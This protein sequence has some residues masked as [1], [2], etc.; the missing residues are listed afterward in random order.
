MLLIFFI[1]MNI[2][3]LIFLLTGV[4]P[5]VKGPS[6]EQLAMREYINKQVEK[7]HEKTITVSN[8]EEYP[9]NISEIIR[10]SENHP[11]H[12]SYNNFFIEKQREI[13]S[14]ISDF[15]TKKINQNEFTALAVNIVKQFDEPFFGG[16]EDL[17]PDNSIA[18]ITFSND[19]RIGILALVYYNYHEHLPNVISHLPK[20]RTTA[21]PN[22]S[23]T[24]TNSLFSLSQK[25]FTQCSILSK[26]RT[27]NRC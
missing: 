17:N 20:M 25:D 2:I 14:I 18:I 24:N 16:Y 23:K 13:D 26:L 15:D 6:E 10:E 8:I 12:S 11:F 27:T 21:R 7:Y 5:F 1:T 3:V 22:R 4:N 9:V 19:V